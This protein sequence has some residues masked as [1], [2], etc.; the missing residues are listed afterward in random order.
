MFLFAIAAFTCVVLHEYGHALTARRYGIPTRDITLLP[1]G[2]IARLERMPSDPRQE[3]VVAIA[4]PAVNV[5]IAAI[6]YVVCLLAGVHPEAGSS[7]VLEGRA[8]F[9]VTLLWWN[10]VMVCFNMLPAFPMDGGRVLRALLAMK[11]NYARATRFAANTG[12]VMAIL[13]AYVAI[14]HIGHPLLIVIA[15]FVWVGAGQEAAAAE[16]KVMLAGVRVRDA[17]IVDFR[18]VGPDETAGTVAQIILQGSQRDF[19]VIFDGKV[20]GIVTWKDVIAGLDSGR[21]LGRSVAVSSF[22]R[23]N[24]PSCGPGENL[25][26]VL[27]RMREQDLAMMPVVEDDR[28]LGLVTPENSV[29]FMLIRRALEGIPA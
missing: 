2:G 3:L 18:R 20:V 16:Q 23:Q 19:P 21:S 29:E 13:F 8:Q 7:E 1:I 28:L 10:V 22:M 27:D 5:A 9:V 6:L 14:F 12:K 17:M 24:I 4:G 25:E 26:E 11:M 15:F